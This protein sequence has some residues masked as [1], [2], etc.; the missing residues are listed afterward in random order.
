MITTPIFTRLLTTQEYGE[1]N[2][3]NSW[4]SIVTVFVTLNL[5]NGVFTR[6]L[7]KYEEDRDRYASAL[8][9]MCTLCIL[10]GFAIYG[11]AHDF[12]NHFFE[13]TTTQALL[14]FIMIWATAVF[15][16]WSVSQR[17]DFKYRALVII[18]LISSIA[19]PVLGIILVRLADDKVTARILGLA[20]V[21]VVTCTGCLLYTS[22]SP[23]DA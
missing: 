14:M 23:R 16:F 7:V 22:P 20:L 12:W 11:V 4:L 15:N 6:G 9:G 3:F 13:M 18:T 19:K 8:Q 17:V 1:F 2:V 21:E 5:Y 10:I